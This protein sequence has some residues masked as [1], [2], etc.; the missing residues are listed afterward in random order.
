MG[1]SL[2]SIGLA[3][4]SCNPNVARHLHKTYLMYG[5]DRSI[6]TYDETQEV[7]EH[8]SHDQT[9]IRINQIFIRVICTL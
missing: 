5:S 9:S 6:L 3:T 8:A 1:V 7:I 4:L 2:L